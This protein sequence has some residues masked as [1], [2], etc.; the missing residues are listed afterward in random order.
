M[1]GRVEE[2]D[3]E[4]EGAEEVEEKEVVEEE[5][6]EV[7]EEEEEEVE[8]ENMKGSLEMPGLVS[9]LKT[10]VVVVER[11]IGEPLRMML[12]KVTK[13]PTI[14]LLRKPQLKEKLLLKAK[15]RTK[16]LLRIRSLLRRR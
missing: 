15:L 6:K 1:M 4:E 14:H 11:A 3:V 9:R 7:W 10:S 5:W 2:G 8:R 12:R 13:L 16:H